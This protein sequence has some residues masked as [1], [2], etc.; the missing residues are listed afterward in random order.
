MDGAGRGFPGGVLVLIVA[1]GLAGAAFALPPFF[2]GPAILV[3]VYSVVAYGSQCLSVA[4]LAVAGRH[5]GRFLVPFRWRSGRWAGQA[6]P[7]ARSSMVRDGRG[8][9][10]WRATRAPGQHG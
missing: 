4:G 1:G 6:V 8:G 9:K 2:L 5:S 3:A 7:Q 10:R